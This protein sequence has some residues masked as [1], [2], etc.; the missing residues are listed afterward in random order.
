MTYVDPSILTTYEA[1]GT[2][3]V[4]RDVDQNLWDMMCAEN[5]IFNMVSK[6]TTSQPKFEWEYSQTNNKYITLTSIGTSGIEDSS[7]STTKAA[8]ADATEHALL[9]AGMILKNA[10]RATP[11]GTTTGIMDELMIVTAVGNA[12]TDGFDVT[13][14]YAAIASGTGSTAHTAGDKLEILYTPLSEGSLASASPNKY[15]KV[16]E[17]SNNVVT[18]DMKLECSG[19]QFARGML[20]AKDNLQTQYENRMLELRNQ[21]ASMILYGVDATG[22][23]SVLRNG[24]GLA[25]FMSGGNVDYTSTVLTPTVLNDIFAAIMDDGGSPSD[26]YAIVGSPYSAQVISAFGEDKVRLTQENLRYGRQVKEFVSDLGFVAPIV[27]EPMCSKSN[28]FVIN[29]RKAQLLTFR[30]FTKWEWGAYT[31]NPNGDDAYHQRTLGSMGL[32][33]VDPTTAH[34]MCV[35]LAWS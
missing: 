23:D 15:K 17:A 6:G 27:A 8:G 22:S 11:I 18:F 9:Q 35:K 24:S 10:S 3:T 25:H 29:R 28:L 34:G 32:K 31:S 12:Y 21:I 5:L 13:R 2:A 1:A 7:G 4:G 20:I 30:P 26:S 19:D 33:L 14:D 16:G